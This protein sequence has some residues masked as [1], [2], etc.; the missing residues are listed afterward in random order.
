MSAIFKFPQVAVHTIDIFFYA[1][2]WLIIY[3]VNVVDRVP[4]AMC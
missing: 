3:L 1:R 2:G 4:E